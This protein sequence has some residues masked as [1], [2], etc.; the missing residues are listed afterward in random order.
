M[1]RIL[2]LSCSRR[3]RADT[4]LLPA[5]ERYDGPA[6]RVLRRF[7]RQ[8]PADA[9]DSFVL[10]ARFGLIPGNQPIPAYD[11]QMTRYRAH[12]LQ[13]EV[14]TAVSTLLTTRNY[15]ALCVCMGHTYSMALQGYDRSISN[16]TSV[17]I[18]AGT[19]GKMIATL[20]DWLY[21]GT[22]LHVANTLGSRPY[23][24]SVQ[25]RGIATTL[26]AEQVFMTAQQ[27]LDEGRDHPDHYV[28]WYVQLNGQRVSPKWLVSQIFALPVSTFTTSDARRV[29]AQLGIEVHRL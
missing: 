5:I 8:A 11:H 14:S 29:L 27:A 18:A 20:Y 25:L 24:G 19:I 3:K 4:G 1:K 7:L 9:L 2:I 22:A 21:Q 16:T 10:S 6:F 13:P 26:T 12:E 28:A 17:T 15:T 23:H